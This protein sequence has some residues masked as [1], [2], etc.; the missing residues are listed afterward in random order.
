M[1][2]LIDKSGNIAYF[3]Q[4][5]LGNLVDWMVTFCLGGTI[6]LSTLL[7]GGV[8]PDTHVWLLPLFC[9]LMVLHG[10]VVGCRKR[11]TK[12]RKSHT[13]D[14]YSTTCMDLGQCD[15][16]QSDPMAWMV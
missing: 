10:S 4:L 9:C 8:R 11:A 13:A 5:S 2:S 15:V 12:A 16:D 7:L 14:V 6:A 3:G 1:P